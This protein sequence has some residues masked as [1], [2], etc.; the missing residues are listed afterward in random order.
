L[1]V[2]APFNSHKLKQ[3]FGSNNPL[4]SSKTPKCAKT[5]WLQTQSRAGEWFLI[6]SQEV[7][8]APYQSLPTISRSG[9][10]ISSIGSWLGVNPQKVQ[11]SMNFA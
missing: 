1:N 2:H 7:A 3:D 4:Q 10:R 9:N 6:W 8:A 11:A 5:A